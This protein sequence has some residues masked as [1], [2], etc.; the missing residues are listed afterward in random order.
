MT[1]VSYSEKKKKGKRR[2]SRRNSLR[3]FFSSAAYCSKEDSKLRLF[4]IIKERR[5]VLSLV[6]ETMTVDKKKEKKAKRKKKMSSSFNYTERWQ[7]VEQ[8]TET[9]VG[10]L[11]Q[12]RIACETSDCDNVTRLSSS[13][14]LHWNVMQ[15]SFLHLSINTRS[16]F[17]ATVPRSV[18]RKKRDP[19]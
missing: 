4:A 13:R 10:E 14:W 11:K 17:R 8:P 19:L 9:T 16:E 1:I 2:S 7:N 6:Q 5:V 15:R 3:L 18:K 12:L